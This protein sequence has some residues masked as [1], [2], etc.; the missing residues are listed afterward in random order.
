MEVVVRVEDVS[1]QYANENIYALQNISF[2]VYKGEWV[3]IVGHNGSGKSTLAKLLIGLLPATSGTI[4]VCG[5]PL[6]E[7]TVWD[8]RE[9][10][11]IVFQTQITSLLERLSK[12]T[13]LLVLKSRDTKDE[14]SKRINEALKKVKWKILFITSHIAYQV[15]KNNV[16][17]LQAPSLFSQMSLF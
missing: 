17:P 12:M 14:M 5:I 3:T 13:L 7:E 16:S 6:N 10:L 2:Q 4:H 15:D 11:G 9:R 1:F 8:V